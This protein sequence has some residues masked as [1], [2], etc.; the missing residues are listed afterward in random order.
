MI[1]H[2]SRRAVVL[3]LIGPLLGLS[4]AC[5]STTAE[6]PDAAVERGVRTPT[7]PAF[8]RYVALGDSYTAAPLIAGKSS[9]DGCF[10]SSNNYPS[11]VAAELDGTDLDDRSC[12]GATTT[13]MTSRQPNAFGGRPWP[14]QFRGLTKDTDLVTL[15]IGGNDFN[16]FSPRTGLCP[17]LRGSDPTGNPCQRTYA[18]GGSDTLLRDA[19]R[20]RG[21]VAAV[22]RGIRKR[23]PEARIVVVDY[24]R[25][26]PTTGTCPRRLPL[27][28]GDYAW[29]AAVNAQLSASVRG[30][31]RQTGAEFVDLYAASGGHDVC[32]DDPWVNGP[33]SEPGTALAYHPLAVEQRAVADLVL[34][35][36][37]EPIPGG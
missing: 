8:E 6:P 24:P 1:S 16:L 11:L 14:A 3:L 31:A 18:S 9:N 36:L 23:A 32:S 33:K 27:S 34:A 12:S 13:N 30:A 19:R 7:A 28:D 5:T 21:R 37:D 10:R 2:R 17:R 20:I 35:L 15:G 4:G 25:I 29:A 26:S 22:I